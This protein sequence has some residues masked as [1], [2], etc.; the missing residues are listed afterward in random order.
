MPFRFNVSK[1]LY[2][3]LNIYVNNYDYND[4]GEANMQLQKYSNDQE[5]FD[6][7]DFGRNADFSEFKRD[8][9]IE[10]MN[11]HEMKLFFICFAA[12]NV[13][14]IVEANIFQFYPNNWIYTD[15]F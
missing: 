6:T 11:D 12:T 8:F 15:F 14:G 1:D 13:V 5:T 9:K 7:D 2:W 10:G 4:Y 3:I